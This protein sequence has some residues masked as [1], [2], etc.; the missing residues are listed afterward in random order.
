MQV[1]SEIANKVLV[2]ALCEILTQV[3]SKQFILAELPSQK[4]AASSPKSDNP[5]VETSSCRTLHL[6]HTYFHSKVR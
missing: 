1:E 3:H 2:H 6:D 5:P 4:P